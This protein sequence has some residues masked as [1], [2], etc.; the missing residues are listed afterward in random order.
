MP[1]CACEAVVVPRFHC[2][3]MSARS[4]AVQPLI[5][6]FEY[7]RR[8]GEA[9]IRPPSHEI[10]PQSRH[11]VHEAFPA[12]PRRDLPDA[13][14]QYR[15]GFRCLSALHDLSRRD[16]ETEAQE[17]ALPHRNHGTL[18]RVDSELVLCVQA[19]QALHHALPRSLRPH[20]HIAV[21][22]VAHEAVPASLQFLVHPVQQHIRQYRRERSLSARLSRSTPCGSLRSL[23]SASERTCTSKSVVML[24][25]QTQRSPFQ[26]SSLVQRNES[27]MTYSHA[28]ILA[29]LEG[30]QRAR[31]RARS[32]RVNRHSNGR[33]T[34]W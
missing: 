17:G 26:G 16:P 11:H 22:G 10:A 9:K 33:A 30:E 5:H 6:A 24:G 14:L 2:L 19:H 12:V 3:R 15:Q 7:L 31:S 32:R 21:I 28:A 8:V 1:R 23:R 18:G 29:G 4:K 25:T 13:L 27:L 34:V 20:V